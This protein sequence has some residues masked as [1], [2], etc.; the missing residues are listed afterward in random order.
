MNDLKRVLIKGGIH[1]D[2]THEE[3]IEL[4]NELQALLTPV[5][6]PIM[7]RI[8][9]WEDAMEIADKVKWFASYAGDI[10][11]DVTCIP[12]SNTDVLSEKRA[13][14]VLAYCK[15]S[16]IA[17]VLNEGWTFEFGEGKQNFGVYLAYYLNNP[18]LDVRMGKTMQQGTLFFRTMALAE[19]AM[20]QFKELWKDYFMIS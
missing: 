20:D 5:S 17:D 8:K 6:V 13:K 19:Y 18:K 14:S 9:T 12:M 1:A 15:L 10:C 4:N 11:Q 7:D 2:L 16:V 3:M